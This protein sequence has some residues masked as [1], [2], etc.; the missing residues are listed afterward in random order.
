MIKPG[1]LLANAGY[2]SNW[3]EVLS[4]PFMRN[5]FIAGSLVAIASGMLGY[6]VVVREGE[7]AAHALGHIGF[8]GATGAV[9]LGLSPTLGLAVF[10]VGGAL[11]IGAL[12]KRAS[13]RATATGTVLA[14]AT[15]L[16]ILFASLATE[17]STTVTNVL[18][19][20]L[21]AVSAGQIKVFVLFTIA[22]ALVL[23]VI[24]RP[25]M[26]ASVNPDVAEAKGVAVK[27]L[28]IVFLVLMGLVVTMAV[29]VVGT[30]L[31]FALVVTPPATALKLTARP[32]RVVLLGTAIGLAAVV[33]GLI[34]ATILNLPPSF[35]I[36]SYSFLTWLIVLGATREQHRSGH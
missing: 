34:T 20:N 17:S 16:G 8:P 7:F 29:Q 25:L 1:L 26:F 9:L 22:L 13:E 3:V 24:A 15:G 33:L 27:A 4:Q 2:Q 19:G 14:F 12:G 6:F 35:F 31:L 10:C 23:A 32:I 18:F 5:A 30:L 11:V 36:V 21:L 28:G